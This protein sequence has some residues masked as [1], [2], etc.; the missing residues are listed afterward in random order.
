MTVIRSAQRRV[1]VRDG[2]HRQELGAPKPAIASA[3]PIS[4]VTTPLIADD[5]GRTSTQEEGA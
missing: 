3:S 1:K 5:L 4:I 2:E